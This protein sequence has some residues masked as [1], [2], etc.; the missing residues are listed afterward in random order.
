[1]E[2][3][4]KSS[5]MRRLL[6]FLEVVIIAALVI[7]ISKTYLAS[8]S[9]R[10]I[11]AQDLQTA[12]RLDPSNSD[13]RLMV[14]RLAQ[15]NVA[16]MNP[17]LAMES[18]RRAAELN[19][20]DPQPWLELAAAFGFQGKN[21]GAEACLRRADFLAPNL[22]SVQWVIGNFFLLRGENDEAF[23]HFRVVLS[24]S[25][26]YSQILFKI[27]WKAT[28]DGQKILEELIPDRVP[29]EIEYLY[30]LLSQKRFA[31]ARSIWKRVAAH[32]EGLAARQVAGY[33]DQLI[34]AHLPA[35]AHEVWDDLK[36]N[37]QIKPTYGPTARNLIVNG[38]FE[39]DLLNLGFDWRIAPVEGIFAGSDGGNYHSPSRAMHIRFSGKENVDYRHV[40][41]YVAVEPGHSYRLT[42]FLKTEGITTD[43]GP[44]LVVHDAYDPSAL[45]KSSESITGSTVGWTQVILDF[46]A[47]P[48]TTLLVVSVA[49]PPS[50]KID[51][52]IDGK[53]WVDDVALV[54][55]PAEE[56]RPR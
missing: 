3:T 39:E 30:F 26:Q 44:R 52:R 18:L 6:A 1:M 15:Y 5:L 24:G 28:D 42:G 29:T 56:A 7:W 55:I 21:S 20:R 13:Y 19:P 31:E 2:L 37:G 38:D 36:I 54:G 4:L 41:Q 51:N 45:Q 27:A 12:V 34:A 48:K 46:T 32:G 25:N 35:E 49:R 10:L 9:G 11:N 40:Y 50:M 33:I 14:G 22:P 47:G 17:D 8:R 23:R 43:S 16:D 53:V